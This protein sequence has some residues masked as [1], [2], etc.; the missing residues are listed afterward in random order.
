MADTL[1]PEDLLED[2]E[3]INDEEEEN[4]IED[5]EEEDAAGYR[6]SVF[7]DF[8]KGDF[9][10]GHDGKL[11]GATGI[12]AWEQWCQKVIQ[13]QR[14]AHEAYSSDIG[15]DFEKAVQAES[16]AEAENILNREITEALMADPAERTQYVGD[17]S[18][19][20]HGDGCD[21]TVPI[22]GIDGNIEVDASYESEVG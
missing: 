15:I 19:S 12:E 16:R 6:Y 3:V 1:F 9:V 2:E 10:A 11:K 17:I 13:T 21:V 7:F 18:F 22:Q 8:D 4:Y 20:W 5:E 14:Y